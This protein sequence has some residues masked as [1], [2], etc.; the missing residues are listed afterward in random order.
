[1]SST[2]NV[3]RIAGVFV[4]GILISTIGIEATFLVIAIVVFGSVVA[5]SMLDVPTNRDPTVKTTW[6]GMT[7]SLREGFAFSM[8]QPATRGVM[9]L[10]VVFYAL[11]L[12]RR[13]VFAPLFA[14]TVMETGALR[15]E[16]Q[17]SE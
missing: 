9:L 3:M 2:Q 6:R 11:A 4:A 14:R 13:Q 12:S 7:T 17:P 15:S 10:S 8:A 5:T 16:E 1:M